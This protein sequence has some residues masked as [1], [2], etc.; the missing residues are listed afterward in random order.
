MSNHNQPLNALTGV[1]VE[2]SKRGIN[3][4]SLVGAVSGGLMGGEAYASASAEQKPKDVTSL[5]DALS[6]A[7]KLIE[8]QA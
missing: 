4:E 7:L 8:I 2:A 1:L 6:E 5:N 3:I